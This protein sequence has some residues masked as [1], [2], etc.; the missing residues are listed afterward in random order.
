MTT[1][2]KH[3]DFDALS[4]TRLFAGAEPQEIE[5]MLDCLSARTKRFKQGEYL[6]LMGQ[7][8]D[9]LGLVLQGAVRIENADAWGNITVMEHVGSGGVFAATYAALPQTPLMVNVVA[10]KDCTVLF[11]NVERILSTCTDACSHHRIV[12]ENLLEIFARKNLDL[13]WRIFHSA[14][15]TIRGRLLSFLSFESSKAGSREF[16]IDFNR[17]QLADY[18]GVDRSALSNELSKMQAEGLLRT[19]RS[20]FVLEES[21]NDG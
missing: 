9:S 16:D 1:N 6:Y 15:K 10:A 20:H 17:Q 5:A 14:P 3:L 4:R 8:I 13:S 11:C 18:L 21:Q 19:H 12:S 2:A 7:S